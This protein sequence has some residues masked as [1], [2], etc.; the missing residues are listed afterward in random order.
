[1]ET[2]VEVVEIAGR[3]WSL[4]RP[5]DAETLLDETRFARDE[6]LPYWAE[7]WPASLA[8][9]DELAG[10]WSERL[11]GIAVLELGCGLGLPSLVA[12]SLGATVVATDWSDDALRQL[13]RNAGANRVSLTTAHLDWT[14]PT[15]GVPSAGCRLV[16]AADV[17][18]EARNVAP[19][20]AFCETLLS[21][22]AELLLADPG[23]RHSA[24]F[25]ADAAE[26]WTVTHSGHPRLPRGGLYRVAP[27]ADG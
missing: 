18:Y 13:A 17:L 6:F 25:L 19:L 26:R 3:V 24:P 12:A 16:L 20:L 23:R 1:M 14:S 10:N 2:V 27:V 9:A 21:G 4:E 7:L 8:L 22:G 5:L 15:A 11:T